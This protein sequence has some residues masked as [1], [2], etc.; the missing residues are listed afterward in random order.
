MNGG[1]LHEL[2]P[3]SA[4]ELYDAAL[5]LC[6][7]TK[8]ELPVLAAIGA[9]PLAACGLWGVWLAT[10][11]QSFELAA[12]LLPIALVFRQLCQGAGGLAATRELEGK[13][14]SAGG[15]LRAGL[16]H[17]PSMITCTG[18]LALFQLVV[19]PLTLG[20]SVFF[21]SVPLVGPVLIAE[22]SAHGWNFGRVAR[23]RLKGRGGAAAALRMLHAL[24]L[25]LMMVNLHGLVW[26]TLEVAH[27][28]FAVDVTFVDQF[29]SLSHAFYDLCLFAVSQVLLD[30]VRCATSALVL[31]D[32]RV[33]HEGFDLLAA[34]RRLRDGSLAKAALVLL[35]LGLALAPKAAH[36]A[37]FDDEPEDD[38]DAMPAPPPPPAKAIQVAP[39]VDDEREDPVD[40]LASISEELGEG[41]NPTVVEGL[42]HAD[43]LPRSERAKL[44]PLVR[45]LDH[46]L[47]TSDDE[48]ARRE[49]LAALDALGRV[50]TRDAKAKPKVT[51][52]RAA[53]AKILAQPEFEEVAKHAKDAKDDPKNPDV[54]A[55][56][57]WTRFWKWVGRQLEKIF[58]QREDKD[59][60]D[61]SGQGLSVGA[62]MAQV[63]TYAL[64]ALA[65]CVVLI[66]VYRLMTQQKPGEAESDAGGAGGAG[67]GKGEELN[68]LAKPAWVWSDEAD[69]LAAS[70]RFREAIRSL[71]L[72]LLASMHRRGAIDY[73][74]A[75]SNWDYCDHFRGEPGELP[76]FRELTL[77]FDFGWYGR[78][79][80]DAEGYGQ[81][82]TLCGPLLQAQTS[83]EAARA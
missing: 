64:V 25:L 14:I 21:L 51:D 45:S 3:R 58:K 67:D 9:A 53:A 77:R 43:E 74:P 18:W 29:S 36:A 6:V 68:A 57:W 69:R 75:L 26:I 17:L 12:A 1:A 73:H 46:R 63:I 13:P 11:G 24:A 42:K 65:A 16:S 76:P 19:F 44:H 7:H 49:L 28:L 54:E 8:S 15:A 47:D 79:G 60:V 66:L 41:E 39:M 37:P 34:L 83:P 10:H 82:R 81:F 70:G 48:G 61:V 59:P 22:G 56:S 30:P 27:S 2:R 5:H 80:A 62:G 33:R 78:L 52:P 20:L 40:A 4:V 31:A 23:A 38:S 32:A 71:Y 72:A 55:P 35:A 50:Q